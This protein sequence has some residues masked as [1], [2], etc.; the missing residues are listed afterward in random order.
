MSRSRYRLKV[1]VTPMMRCRGNFLNCTLAGCVGE[2]RIS[3]ELI[4]Q[5]RAQA[6]RGRV[7]IKDAAG[8]DVAIPLFEA[9][10]RRSML[11]QKVRLPGHA[12]GVVFKL[13]QKDFERLA[14]SQTSRSMHRQMRQQ[15]RH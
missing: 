7:P 4:K 13:E 9:S 10:P 12:I 5:W 6:E 1:S 14:P 2:T 8:R 15:S 3:D 11:W